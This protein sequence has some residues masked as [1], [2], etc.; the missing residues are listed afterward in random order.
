MDDKTKINLSELPELTTKGGGIIR[1]LFFSPS[2]L[3]GSDVGGGYPLKGAASVPGGC[4]QSNIDWRIDG[5]TQDPI[6][7]EMAWEP[8]DTPHLDITPESLALIHQH[9]TEQ[10]LLTH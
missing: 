4:R 7:R 9:L 2:A 8:Y 10:R 6:S 5:L 1:E 3:R